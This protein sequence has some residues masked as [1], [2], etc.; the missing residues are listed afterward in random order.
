MRAKIPYILLSIFVL[1]L[2]TGIALGE[3]DVVIGVAVRICLGCMG[4]G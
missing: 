1:C 4:I 3:A 2:L